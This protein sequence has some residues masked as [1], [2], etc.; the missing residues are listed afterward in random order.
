MKKWML[1]AT[2]ALLAVNVATAQA[3]RGQRNPK[4]MTAKVAERLHFTD[5]QMKQLSALNEKYP[6]D[7]FDRKQYRDEFRGI[8]TEEQKA[9]LEQMKGD[10]MKQRG[11]MKS[12]D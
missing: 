5:A 4:M 10:R 3:G 6:G 7:D 2:A 9:Q 12:E 11:K 1:I 8:M